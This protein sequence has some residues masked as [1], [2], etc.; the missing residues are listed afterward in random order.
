MLFRW[1]KEQRSYCL[2]SWTLREKPLYTSSFHRS[3]GPYFRANRMANLNRIDGARLKRPSLPPAQPRAETETA[4]G[5]R[6][7]G[8]QEIGDQLC[9]RRLKKRVGDSRSGL[10]REHRRRDDFLARTECRMGGRVLGRRRSRHGRRR[11]ADLPEPRRAFGV[12]HQHQAMA[13]AGLGRRRV[14]GQSACGGERRP[15]DR[16]G[17]DLRLDLAGGEGL[18]VDFR[19]QPPVDHHPADQG[20]PQRRVLYSQWAA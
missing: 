7:E 12:E 20:R 15:G 17:D 4:V 6:V 1:E 18:A 14:G 9:H 10:G 13:A 3:Q 19:R 8:R 16:P 11:G 2:R 5:R